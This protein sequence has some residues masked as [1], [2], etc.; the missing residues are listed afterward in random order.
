MIVLLGR[1][2]HVRHI[3][4]GLFERRVRGDRILPDLIGVRDEVNLGVLL[5]VE[6]SGLF[7]VEIG[8][9]LIVLVVIEKGFIG[10]NHF[11][12]GVEPRPHFCAKIDDRFDSVC[13]QKAVAEDF[14]GLLTDTIHAARPLDEPNDRPR[15]VIVHDDESV[16]E[17]LSFTQ[18]IGGNEDAQLLLRRNGLLVALRTETIG[19]IRD[20]L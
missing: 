3:L 1:V 16:L 14:V 19:K 18:D 6:K 15:Q 20:V 11:R 4:D 12:V 10:A 2:D 13:W 5:A 8:N 9:N 7:V 17:V